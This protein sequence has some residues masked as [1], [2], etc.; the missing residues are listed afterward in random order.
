L[1]PITL[2]PGCFIR[3]LSGITLPA[4][5]ELRAHTGKRL[6]AFTNSTLLAHFGLSGPGVLDISRYYLDAAAG[7]IAAAEP[8]PVLVLNFLPDQ[9]LEAFDAVLQGLGKRS[10]LSLLRERLPERL[11]LAL[12][13]EA[14]ID[15][16]TL[17]AG[18]SREQRRALAR[19]ATELPL[20]VTGDRGFVHAEVT[21]GGVPLSEL[22]LNTMESRVCPGLHV[23]GELCDVDGRIGGFNFQWA[24]ASGYLAGRASGG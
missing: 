18:L 21:A 22:H 16:A 10:P 3:E 23:I 4:T 5:I 19:A 15:P 1:V 17:G 2:A 14:R 12:L 20:P 9:T 8:P 6:I 7:A 11:A 13:T 24:W